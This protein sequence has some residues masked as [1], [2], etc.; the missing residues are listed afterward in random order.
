MVLLDSQQCR[1]TDN[2]WGEISGPC[3][4][5][6]HLVIFIR[7]AIITVVVPITIPASEMP[8]IQ[9]RRWLEHQ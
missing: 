3:C 1:M 2:L 8:S 9:P 5:D 6:L 7:L 4:E